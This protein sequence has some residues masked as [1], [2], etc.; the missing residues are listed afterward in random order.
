MDWSLELQPLRQ[1]YHCDN[2]QL[3]SIV[4]TVLLL[5]S[6]YMHCNW[7][8]AISSN[9]ATDSHLLIARKHTLLYVISHVSLI[10]RVIYS[11]RR[12]HRSTICNL[13][14]SSIDEAEWMRDKD[15]R[16]TR[17]RRRRPRPDPSAPSPRPQTPCSTRRNKETSSSEIAGPSIPRRDYCR[18]RLDRAM[19]SLQLHACMVDF[20]S[21]DP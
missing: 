6:L 20:E 21:M 19:S 15:E 1:I 3:I 14:R 18:R 8:L 7:N 2:C 4:V 11:I 13:S 16:Y 17:D 5:S 10:I 9:S 12:H